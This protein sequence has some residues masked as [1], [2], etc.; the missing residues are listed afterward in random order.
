MT[1]TSQNVTSLDNLPGVT[2][3]N[4]SAAANCNGGAAD[5]ELFR[6]VN[7]G[8]DIVDINRDRRNLK[9]EGLNFNDQTS[10]IKINEGT[11]QFFD[12]SDYRGE[13][14]TLGPG[15]YSWVEDYGLKN[16]T[17]SSLRRI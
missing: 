8:G 3:I 6:D 17:L 10:S 15:E 13:P 14:V 5:V 12:P 7:F 1:Y 11:W 2:D 16:D 4:D 9:K